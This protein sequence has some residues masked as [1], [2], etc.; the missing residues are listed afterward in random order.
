MPG[1]MDLNFCHDIWLV[2][3]NSM[4]SLYLIIMI[5]WWCNCVGEIFVQHFGLLT[6]NQALFKHQSLP[7]CCRWPYP[8]LYDHSVPTL[9]GPS[10]KITYCVTKLK[11]YEP[12]CLN[13][14]SS[15]YPNVSTNLQQLRDAIAPICTKISE[16]LC[17]IRHKV[18]NGVLTQY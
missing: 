16:E 11:S 4:N 14:T 1:L 9:M 8:A 2:G 6:S 18:I 15:L 10:S 12:G 3:K 7:E 13:M 17:W 5:R